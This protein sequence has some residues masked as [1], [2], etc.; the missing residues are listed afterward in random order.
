MLWATNMPCV[1]QKF[2]NCIRRFVALAVNH[3]TGSGSFLRALRHWATTK[4]RH[5][6]KQFEPEA[7]G[8]K[9]SD[10]ELVPMVRIRT[11]RT[12]TAKGYENQDIFFPAAALHPT[13]ETDIF[14]A[15][16]LCYVPPY[17][18]YFGW[19]FE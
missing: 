5:L 12:E 4:T 10:K 9:L 11:V 2:P 19:D 14:Q 3:F 18:R 17:M 1:S 6:V 16:G 7:T 13:C 8:F 15:L